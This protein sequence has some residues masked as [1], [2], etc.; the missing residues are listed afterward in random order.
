MS[1]SIARHC[2]YEIHP[3]SKSEEEMS[4]ALTRQTVSLTRNVAELVAAQ[5]AAAP[6]ALAI[7]GNGAVMTYGEMDAR[8]NGLVN[9]LITSG[10]GLDTSVGLCLDRS[11][12][13]F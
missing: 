13:S 12:L 11:T 2:S 7:A 6:H 3:P 8:A 4:P 1:A 9:N 10:L 5:A